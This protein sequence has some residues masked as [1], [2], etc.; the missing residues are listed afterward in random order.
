MWCLEVQ[1]QTNPVADARRLALADLFVLNGR[2]LCTMALHRLGESLLCG[3]VSASLVCVHS[4]ALGAFSNS[5]TVKQF[6]SRDES[7]SNSRLATNIYLIRTEFVPVRLQR[8]AAN[9]YSLH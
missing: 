7:F 5:T 6:A 8:I 2:F 3:D 4:V 9:L 1:I